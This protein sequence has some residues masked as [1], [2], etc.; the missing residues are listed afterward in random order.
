[1]KHIG[2]VCDKVKQA[3]F[4]A[5]RKKSEY[6]ASCM[7]VL[8]HIINDEGLKALPE[9]IAR[10]KAWT[11]PRN[12]KKLRE[13]LEVV[14]YISQFIPHLTSITALLTLLTGI[15]SFCRLQRMTR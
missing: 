1:M 3:K 8:G 4:Y 6:F 11:T 10:I 14:N 15:E 9:K 7:D 12:E 2:M 13:F 5:S